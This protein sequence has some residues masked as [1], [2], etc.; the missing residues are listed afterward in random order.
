[1]KDVVGKSA[2]LPREL[3]SVITSSERTDT[4]TIAGQML[5]VL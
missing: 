5:V 4:L 3:C 1:L 2:F